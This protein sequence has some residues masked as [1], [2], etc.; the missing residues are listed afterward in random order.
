MDSAYEPSRALSS[1]TFASTPKPIGHATPVPFAQLYP[2]GLFA[3]LLPIALR[4]E[5]RPQPFLE[6]PEALEAVI[7]RPTIDVCLGDR[8]ACAWTLIRERLDAINECIGVVEH[9]V[10][11]QVDPCEP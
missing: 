3:G 7:G 10:F 11:D 1:V 2:F 9:E 6:G 5:F 4:L 8:L